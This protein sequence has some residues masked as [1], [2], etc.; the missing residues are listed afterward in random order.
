MIHDTNYGLY[1][2]LS[3]AIGHFKKTDKNGFMEIEKGIVK[4]SY[5]FDLS[6][7]DAELFYDKLHEKSDNIWKCLKNHIPSTG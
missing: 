4:L 2:E 5:N 6:L 3:I 7:Y 1:Y